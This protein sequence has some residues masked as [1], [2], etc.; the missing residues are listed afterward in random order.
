[1]TPEIKDLHRYVI[2]LCA[3][4]W[5]D[6]GL[7][8]NLKTTTLDSILK[9]NP[10]DCKACFKSTLAIWLKSN[11]NATWRMLEVA[12]TNVRRAHNDLDPVS[13]IYGK[14]A[15]ISDL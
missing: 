13:D 2:S 12:I 8:L 15:T 1:M 4:D 10:S 3:A 6:V 5:R 14:Y 11:P 9:D 7:E